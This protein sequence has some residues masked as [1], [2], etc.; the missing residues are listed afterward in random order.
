MQTSCQLTKARSKAK[1]AELRACGCEPCQAKDARN[2]QKRAEAD[3]RRKARAKGTP[4]EKAA[5]KAGQLA[6]FVEGVQNGTSHFEPDASKAHQ[7]GKIGL[8]ETEGLELLDMHKFDRLADIACRAMVASIPQAIEKNHGIAAYVRSDTRGH[9]GEMEGERGSFAAIETNIDNAKM[10]HDTMGFSFREMAD[11]VYTL[12]VHGQPDRDGNMVAAA[13]VIRCAYAEDITPTYGLRYKTA[14]ELIEAGELDRATIEAMVAEAAEVGG[15][16]PVSFT[17]W[18]RTSE[19]A[20]QERHAVN[21][22]TTSW[23]GVGAKSKGS[24]GGKVTE[25][26]HR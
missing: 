8:N 20:N 13:V 2:L 7:L 17:T 9:T 26:A 14:L 21:T 25:R 12:E 24:R 3:A 11:R 4:A 10:A 5:W 23:E 15:F 6:K 22:P 1:D 19:T 16:E 18:M